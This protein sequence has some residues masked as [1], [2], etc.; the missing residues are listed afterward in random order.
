MIERFISRRQLNDSNVRD[1]SFLFSFQ[2][3]G[4][5]YDVCC[6]MSIFSVWG[7]AAFGFPKVL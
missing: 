4:G 6:R 5:R 1:Y 2:H 7:T 3:S